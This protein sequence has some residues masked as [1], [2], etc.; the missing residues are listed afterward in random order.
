MTSLII[1]TLFSPNK[2]YLTIN[3]NGIINT[4]RYLNGC[5]LLIIGWANDFQDEINQF[6]KNHKLNFGSIKTIFYH[7][8]Y[9]KKQIYNDLIQFDENYEYYIFLDH[10]ILFDDVIDLQSIYK[11]FDYQ[12]NGKNIGMIIFNQTEDCRHQHDI[13]TYHCKLINFNLCWPKKNESIACGSIITKKIFFSNLVKFDLDSV[14]G[15]DD[16]YLTNQYDTLGLAKIILQDIFVIHPFDQNISYCQW[17]KESVIK[18]INGKKNN[19]YADVLESKI[20]WKSI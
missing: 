11:L 17:K 5:D 4:S 15:L 7:F 6:I 1:R 13:Y 16:V 2:E 3:M 9:G 18:M 10:D 14:Y 12:I 20:F 19:Y 8:N